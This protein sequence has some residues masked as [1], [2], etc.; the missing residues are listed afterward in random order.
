MSF[1]FTEMKMIEDMLLLMINY[2]L[3]MKNFLGPQE[4]MDLQK[5]PMLNLGI[6]TKVKFIFLK[7]NYEFKL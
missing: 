7:R 1:L 2:L 4:F 6:V 3:K 5:K